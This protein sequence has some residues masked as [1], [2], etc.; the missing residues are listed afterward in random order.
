MGRSALNIRGSEI[1]RGPKR[2]AAAI[3]PA[4]VFVGSML[5]L[6]PI[7][8]QTGW[9]PDFGFIML[10]AWRLLRGDVW[11]AWWAAPLG[12]ANDL[13]TGAPIGLSVSLWTAAMLALDLTDRRTMW[14]DY[15]IEWVLAIVLIGAS[16]LAQWRI[17][18]LMGAQTELRSLG[19][20]MLIAAFCFPL[21]AWA[22]ARL[23]RWRLGR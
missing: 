1:D 13:I 10:I 14:R 18:G 2:S 22:V 12:L 11:P 17:A 21:A 8:T 9:V 15:W 19:P 23:D 16:E 4:S 6:L 3:P 20:R 5:A 7:V